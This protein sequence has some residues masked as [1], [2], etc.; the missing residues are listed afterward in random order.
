M[1]QTGNSLRSS[2]AIGL[3][4]GALYDIARHRDP[5]TFPAS[6]AHALGRAFNCDSAAY[7]RVDA[8][9]P[10]LAVSGWPEAA[11][12]D[13]DAASILELHAQDHPL[14][15]RLCASRSARAWNL[16]DLITPEAFRKTALY[17]Q[18]YR[19]RGIEYQ[20]AML[21]PSPA[22]GEHAICLHRRHTPFTEDDRELLELLW[23]NLAQTLRNLRALS[24]AREASAVRTVVDESGIIVLDHE[25]RVELCTEQARIWLT[26]YCAQ[27]FPRRKI[28]LPPRVAEWARSRLR[29]VEAGAAAALIP[30]GHRE[31]LVLA[32]GES[33]LTVN[34][35]ADHGRGQ[36]LLVLEEESLRVPPAT[37]AG[38]GLTGRETEVLTW[39]AQGKTNPEI[40][41]ILGMSARTV[42][43]HLEHVFE[44]LGV[45][46]RTGAILKAWQAGRFASLAPR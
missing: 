38:F 31:K 1:D 27:S 26:R 42:Q 24:R 4:L 20:L 40:G 7:V 22:S 46:S 21:L 29:E 45:E 35:I 9:A 25:G 23:P 32:E 33:F 36:H 10:S 15:A 43:K 39:V 17:R 16:H 30:S 12:Q 14:V 6:L 41:I 34:L 19:P 28:E 11:W 18:L 37:L 5:A 2:A 44:K 3:A 8:A 13:I